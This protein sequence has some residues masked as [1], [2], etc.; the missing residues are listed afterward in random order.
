M[1]SGSAI[2]AF[3]PQITIE[4]PSLTVADPMELFCRGAKNE[5]RQKTSSYHSEL[6]TNDTLQTFF[7]LVEYSEIGICDSIQLAAAF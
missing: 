1:G 3:I 4:F 5:S 2:S 6:L 7:R